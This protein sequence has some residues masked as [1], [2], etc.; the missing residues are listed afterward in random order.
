M[1]YTSKGG[2]TVGVEVDDAG[3]GNGVRIIVTDT[4]SGIPLSM[5]KGLLEATV[6]A[7]AQGAGI[8]L[9]TSNQTIK[10]LAN[11][12]LELRSSEVGVG[13]VWCIHLVQAPCM[14]VGLKDHDEVGSSASHNGPVRPEPASKRAKTVSMGGKADLKTLF[15]G[16][17]VLVDDD[18]L[19]RLATRGALAARYEVAVK[20]YS[21]GRD[22]LDG[23]FIASAPADGAGAAILQQQRQPRCLILM[24]H[25]MPLM[26]GEQAVGLVPAG[27][28][29]A[30]AMMS[31]TIFTTAD[32]ARIRGKGVAAF[33]E[34]PLEW[35]VFD[36]TV[37]DIA[38][39]DL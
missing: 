7:T 19:A 20:V 34:K 4:G 27:H 15:P 26:D 8:G 35:Q 23:M 1:R 3:H 21:S 29:H 6:G 9:F 38:I 2:I 10:R 16:G 5:Q 31:G 28:P 13:T 12:R 18:A 11:G 17:V 33:F 22:F 37:Q 32:R 39:H 30:I 14:P 25:L 24:D 36:A